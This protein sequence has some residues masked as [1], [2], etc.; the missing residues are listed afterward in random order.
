MANEPKITVKHLVSVRYQASAYAIPYDFIA[1]TEEEARLKLHEWLNRKP[2]AKPDDEDH[3]EK[4]ESGR[5]KS[6]LGKVWLM[7]HAKKERVRVSPDQV[8]DYLGRGYERGSPR[9]PF[10]SR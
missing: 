10:R 7:H 2:I 9:T 1:T 3:E 4:L 5:G 8:S 6:L